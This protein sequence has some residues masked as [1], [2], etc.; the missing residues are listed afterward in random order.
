MNIIDSMVEM[1]KTVSSTFKGFI[2]YSQKNT[3]LIN[4]IR[5]KGRRYVGY[6]A[7]KDILP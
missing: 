6:T 1:F 4:L 5:L 2:N 7:M 3:S